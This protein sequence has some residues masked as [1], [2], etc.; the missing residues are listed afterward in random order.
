MVLVD[1]P[2]ADV[3]NSISISKPDYT[4]QYKHYQTENN[5]NSLEYNYI[6]S[7]ELTESNN[8]KYQDIIW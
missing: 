2:T 3:V 7:E 1:L 8:Q 4:I 5:K 6:K